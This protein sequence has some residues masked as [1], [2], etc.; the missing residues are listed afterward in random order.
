VNESY[1]LA[2]EQFRAVIKQLANMKLKILMRKLLVAL[3]PRS[4]L[5]RTKLSNGALIYGK[6]RAGYG[7]RGIFIFRDSLEPE[8]QYLEDFLTP[9]GVFVDVGAN[10]GIY[11]L[12]AAKHYS[13]NGNGL[14]VALE[15]FPDV[16]ATLHYNVQANGFTN[17]R[18]RNFCAGNHTQPGKFWMNFNKPNSFSLL[19]RDKNALCLSTLIVSLDDLFSW[20]GLDRLDYLK[21]DVEGLEAEVLAGGTNT[22]N[23]Y[24][25][26][27]LVEV[28]IKEVSSMPKD[29]SSFSVPG[30]G[31]QLWL[32]NESPKIGL[33][34]KLGWTRLGL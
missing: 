23:K 18:L 8:F 7:G 11:T 30:S 14:V 13:T 19:R 33:P 15:P 12:K 28:T 29:Y 16:L 4:W 31:N 21:I 3:T 20:E 9:S 25:P 17:V 24:R 10:T 22:I 5:L 32:P 26:I 27:I 2:I 34:Q 6:N 1:A